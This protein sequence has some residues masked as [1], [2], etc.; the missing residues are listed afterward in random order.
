[1][2][3]GE[4]TVDDTTKKVLVKL[5]SGV[6]PLRHWRKDFRKYFLSRIHPS[7]G[8]IYPPIYDMHAK[9]LEGHPAI[10]N[11]R[12]EEMEMYFLRDR[13]I[14]SA[15][16]AF[17]YPT[18]FLWDRFNVGL[19]THFYTH[20]QMLERMGSPSKR[21]GMLNESEGIVPHDYDLFRRHPGLERE[22]TLIFTHSER[23]L[24]EVDNARFLPSCANLWY[25]TNLG[26]G[27]LD[28]NAYVN[29]TK[30][31]S[32]VS[33]G[34]VS[35]ALHEYRL[36]CARRCRKEALADTYGTFDGGSSIKIAESLAD[37]R[38]SIAIENF[39]SPYFF[40]EKITNC[41]ASMTVPI[42]LGAS[43]IE[44]FFNEAGIIRLRPNDDI[45]KVLSVCSEKD[46]F[47]R[48]DAIKENYIRALEYRNVWDM[49]YNQYL[50]PEAPPVRL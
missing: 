44:D 16:Y 17:P 5:A 28:G 11:A 27:E 30:N 35:C 12:G 21:Y 49:M 42:Y 22:F 39:I 50:K 33:S 10:F 46:Y 4:I 8:Q 29:K 25:G 13:H 40:T 24:N 43:K 36:L 23:I 15:P 1:M 26:G 31:V 2:Q 6:I 3:N 45:K 14:A 38:Y 18:H 41:F 48:L 9:I 7:Y 20:N 19:D 37:Y 47:S 34:K 32:I